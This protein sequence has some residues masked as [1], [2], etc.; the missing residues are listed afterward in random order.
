MHLCLV[1]TLRGSTYPNGY[2]PDIP[3]RGN[4]TTHGGD[5]RTEKIILRMH[6][7]VEATPVMIFFACQARF[8]YRV[9]L[10]TQFPDSL[11]MLAWCL[12]NHV[13]LWKEQ[14]EHKSLNPDKSLFTGTVRSYR[15]VHFWRKNNRDTQRNDNDTVS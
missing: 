2:L 5:Q 13:F 3:Y 14:K 10:R 7:R 15:T 9:K 4:T 11:L 1:Q 6:S 12:Q 8:T